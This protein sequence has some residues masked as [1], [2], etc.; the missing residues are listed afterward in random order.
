M[1][2]GIGA[3]APDTQII[4]MPLQDLVQRL[5]YGPGVTRIAIEPTG[6]YEKPLVAALRQANLPV[7]LVHTCA[8]QG[9]SPDGWRQRQVG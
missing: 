1:C 9:L 6:G 4:P 2:N 7:E 5:R 8:L 3:M